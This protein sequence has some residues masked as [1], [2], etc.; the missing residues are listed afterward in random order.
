MAHTVIV[1]SIREVEKLKL[2]RPQVA[3]FTDPLNYPKK[4]IGKVM[5]SGK[6]T[7]ILIV[8][9]CP[10]ALYLDIHFNTKL[11]FASRGK[12]DVPGLAG[13]FF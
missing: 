2:E 9:D 5:D 3:V 8:A 12:D 1:K 11:R 4:T 6:G 10:A 13:V 7:N